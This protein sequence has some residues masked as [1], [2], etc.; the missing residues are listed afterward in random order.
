MRKSAEICALERFS[1][2]VRTVVM[3]NSLN[4]AI[5][6]FLRWSWTTTCLSLDV[7]AE[8]QFSYLR[9]TSR[10][11]GTT[12]ACLQACWPRSRGL[13]DAGGDAT[14]G[15]NKQSFQDSRKAVAGFLRTVGWH[16][17]LVNQDRFKKQVS[18]YWNQSQIQITSLLLRRKS[19]CPYF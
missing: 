2:N 4:E 14:A 15:A 19:A 18:I 3:L 13:A 6:G 8:Q 11:S 9:A 10:S 5:N 17:H 12:H 1:L 7:E 16:P